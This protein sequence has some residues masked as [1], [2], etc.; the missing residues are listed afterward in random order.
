MENTRYRLKINSGVHAGSLFSCCSHHDVLWLNILWLSVCCGLLSVSLH[1]VSYDVARV[2][3]AFSC[4]GVRGLSET[5]RGAA[6][7]LLHQ[8]FPSK[9]NHKVIDTL[10]GFA[11]LLYGPNFVPDSLPSAIRVLNC[12]H[13]TNSRP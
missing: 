10:L 7:R 3:A 4:A 11:S 6:R 9:H 5:Q 1:T 2:S 12:I 13:I 8:R